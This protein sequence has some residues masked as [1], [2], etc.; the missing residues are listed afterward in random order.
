MAQPPGW[1]PDPNGSPQLRWWD[2]ERWTE[3]TQLA[4]PPPTG[5]TD[6]SS[7]PS[8]SPPWG[9]G[10]PRRSGPSW[11]VIAAVAAGVVVLLII[12]G[13]GSRSD[14]SVASPTTSVAAEV[15]VTAPSTTRAPTTTAAPRGNASDTLACRH[16][17]NIMGDIGAGILTTAEVRTKFQ[18]VHQDARLGTP[19]V[20][21]AAQAAL[22]AATQDD[23][24]AFLAA[25]SEL[26]R[27]C[28]DVGA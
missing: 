1:Q 2:G 25:V 26:H 22:A 13:I 3:H 24:E 4:P 9:A 12:V 16:F 17:R 14:D 6:G 8:Q 21:A 7:Q 11:K 10:Q 20:A 19:A 27:A 28:A 23:G 18:E 15:E 5:S